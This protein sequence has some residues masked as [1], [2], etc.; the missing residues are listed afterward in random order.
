MTRSHRPHE[1]RARRPRNGR[2]TT[3]RIDPGTGWELTD[4]R[5]LLD[6]GYQLEQVKRLTGWPEGPLLA[7]RKKV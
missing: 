4:A 1:P 2:V 6:D 3:G 7:G 5:K